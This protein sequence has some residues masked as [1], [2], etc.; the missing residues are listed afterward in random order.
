MS[1]W[2]TYDF[3]E[4][5][6]SRPTDYYRRNKQVPLVFAAMGVMHQKIDALA[7][8]IYESENINSAVGSELDRFGFYANVSRN[9]M[10]DDDYRV[11]ILNTVLSSLYSGT[12]RQV[13]MLAASLTQ[14][15]DIEI[16]EMPF[17]AFNLHVTGLVVPATI[18]QIIDNSSAAG[19]KAYTTHDYGTGG[20]S[21]AGIDSQSG[22]ALRT[23]DSEALEVAD[24]TAMGLLRGTAFIGGSYLDSVMSFISDGGL[25][26]T[27]SQFI[28][29]ADDDYYLIDSGISSSAIGNT[30]LAGTMPR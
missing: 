11:E 14:S 7:Q 6:K 20:F 29:I 8:Y 28:S 17:A 22:V 27:D 12:S 1:D 13:M 26:A 23:G 10:N 30:R 19:V 5:I 24:D 21:L 3:I 15:T 4:K 2:V 18:S 16:V 9:G 25:L